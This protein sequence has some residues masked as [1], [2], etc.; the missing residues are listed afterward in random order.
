[1]NSV[2][3]PVYKELKLN[4]IILGL[5]NDYKNSTTLLDRKPE[6]KN[7]F[8][9]SV[10]KEFLATPTEKFVCLNTILS[11][12]LNILITLSCFDN[13]GFDCNPLKKFE[14][15]LEMGKIFSFLVCINNNGKINVSFN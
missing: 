4:G 6:A 5:E 8:F 9:R 7:K 11:K 15:K 13:I 3:D 1:L 2:I 12:N 14:I 10:T